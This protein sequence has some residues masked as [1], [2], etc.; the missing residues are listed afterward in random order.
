LIACSLAST[1]AHTSANVSRCR[2]FKSLHTYVCDDELEI[3]ANNTQAERWE[4]E[5][6]VRI[7]VPLHCSEDEGDQVSTRT[8]TNQ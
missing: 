5:S 3:G 1:R 6:P 8:N 4:R 2:R 7:S